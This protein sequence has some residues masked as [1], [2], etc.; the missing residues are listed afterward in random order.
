M[1][2]LNGQHAL[3]TGGGTGVG[4]AIA[5]CL[6]EA[7][8]AIT[9]AG[10]RLAPL[11]DLAKQLPKAQAIQ[12]DVTDEESVAA[13]FA[14][15]AETFGPVTIAVANA[16]AA[17]S[18][19]I[20]KTD[21]ALWESSLAVNLTGAFLTAREALASM[22][23]SKQGRIIFVASTAG[24]KGY[25]YVSPY[26][27]AKHGVIGLTKAL[28]LEVAKEGITVNAICPGF[29]ETPLL[30]D[31]ITNIM[32]KTGRDEEAARASLLKTNPQ[33][34]FIQPEEI[35]ETALWLC[36]SQASSITGQAISVSGGET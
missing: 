11:Q 33:G 12:C 31:S 7:G 19:P 20:G 3:I 34:R 6:S 35:A 21:M 13:L 29:T 23:Q 24:L 28:A 17:K 2:D 26:C 16:G 36:S 9:I 8:A 14:A 25:A 10:R 1:A 27:A 32:E 4:A 18:A 22:R 15:A 30:Q 5:R